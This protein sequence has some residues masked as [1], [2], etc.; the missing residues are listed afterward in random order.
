VVCIIAT[1][2]AAWH[3]PSDQF[4]TSSRS[5]LAKHPRERLP[6]PRIISLI[7]SATEIVHALGMGDFMV[8][9]S[10]ECDFPSTVLSL[11][12][13]TSPKFA[14]SGNSREIDT[15]VKET[16]QTAL[17]VYQVDEEL[18]ERLQPTL[19]ITQSHCDVCAV[20][21]RDVEAALSRHLTC[22]PEIVSLQPNALADIW[23]DI[24]RV[25]SALDRAATGERLIEKL[26][27]HL[28]VTSVR[29]IASPQRPT[30]ACLEWIEPL[31]AGGNWVPELVEMAGGINL[32]GVAGKHSPWLEWNE[33][34]RHDPDRIVVMPC[35]FDLDRTEKEM[36]W[37]TKRREWESLRAVKGGQVYLTDGN[38]YFNRPGP[39]VVESLQILAE[40]LHPELFPPEL[41]GKGWKKFGERGQ[42]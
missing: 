11:P 12:A 18:L 19:I 15:L 20:S 31:M 33:L 1:R 23:N 29:A 39:R 35:G 2:V 32:F 41:E 27:H 28:N 38:Q 16:L 13:C 26:K 4:T 10:H 6:V 40:I 37:L 3:N 34:C 30:V 25:A 22:Q 7:A 21:L 14:I 24:L 5:G 9:R 36:Y 17:S 42:A 8:A